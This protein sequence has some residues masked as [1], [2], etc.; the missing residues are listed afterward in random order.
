MTTV[1]HRCL[2]RAATPVRIVVFG[3]RSL[4]RFD[5]LIGLRPKVNRAIWGRN[6]A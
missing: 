5:N 2:C 1:E 4:A 6:L 3:E